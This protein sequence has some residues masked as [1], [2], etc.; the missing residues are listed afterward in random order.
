MFISLFCSL[1]RPLHTSDAVT[2]Q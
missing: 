1:S 2:L